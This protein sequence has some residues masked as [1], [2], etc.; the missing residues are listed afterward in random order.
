MTHKITFP[1]I[2]TIA[3]QEYDPNE[4]NKDIPSIKEIINEMIKL[5][6]SFRIVD[7]I[8]YLLV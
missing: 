8:L 6:I 2:K 7:I 1:R 5:Y 4:K 3:V